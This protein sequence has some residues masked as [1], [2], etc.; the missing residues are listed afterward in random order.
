MINSR[1]TWARVLKRVCKDYGLLL[2]S[3]PLDAMSLLDLQKI[4]VSPDLFQS[5]LA[6]AST[7]EIENLLESSPLDETHK[8]IDSKAVEV[9]TI[10][11]FGYG[12][13]FLIPGGRFLLSHFLTSLTLYDLGVPHVHPTPAPSVICE[14]SINLEQECLLD[15]KVCAIQVDSALVRA[16]ISYELATQDGTNHLSAGSVLVNVHHWTS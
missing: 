3:Y 12:N 14:E 16:A 4:S 11:W 8:P 13:A 1:E 9:C 15:S 5:R 7:S 6:M 2:A 10:P